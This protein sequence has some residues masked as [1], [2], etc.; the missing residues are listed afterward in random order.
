MLNPSA[1]LR[2]NSVKDL[3]VGGHL[4]RFFAGAQNDILQRLSD[5]PH[6]V[7]YAHR[8]G[9]NKGLRGFLQCTMNSLLS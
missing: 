5:S 3:L 6:Q 4:P 1:S 2:V 9:Y 8:V 7:D